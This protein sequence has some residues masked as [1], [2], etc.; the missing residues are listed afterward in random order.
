M[1]STWAYKPIKPVIDGEPSYED[2]PIGL[3]FPEGPRW[4]A[5]DVRR[6][7]YWDVFAGAFGHTY[8]HN[9]I[10]QMAKPGYAVAYAD[11]SKTWYR[12]LSSSE[13]PISRLSLQTMVGSTTDS[14]PR[15]A[16]T[17]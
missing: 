11:K 12:S 6:Y 15:A 14:W 2:I 7:A 13:G 3:H 1:D 9:A 5:S 4:Q 16:T 10:M 17:I 8:G